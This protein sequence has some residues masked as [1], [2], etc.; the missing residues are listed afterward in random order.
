M[1]GHGTLYNEPP[2]FPEKFRTHPAAVDFDFVHLIEQ[3]EYHNIIVFGSHSMDVIDD[4]ERLLM[5][6]HDCIDPN[7][8]CCC[9]K[10]SGNGIVVGT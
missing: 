8:E 6:W 7:Q 1:G 2:S 5:V 4:F 9:H 3:R 10:R